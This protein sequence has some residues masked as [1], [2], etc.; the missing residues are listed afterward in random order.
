MSQ[1][2][3]ALFILLASQIKIKSLVSVSRCNSIKSLL[4]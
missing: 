4:S 1:L 2:Y 3:S